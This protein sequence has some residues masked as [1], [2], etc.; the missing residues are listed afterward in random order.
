[1]TN[2]TNE[3][4]SL[5]SENIVDPLI[6]PDLEKPVSES[7]KH[8]SSIPIGK[9]NQFAKYRR[10]LL[11]APPPRLMQNGADDLSDAPMD[12]L[13]A[14]TVITRD[15]LDFFSKLFTRIYH[16]RFFK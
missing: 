12:I 7:H 9:Y 10:F 3:L 2:F 1:M 5:Q 13:A 8:P 14:S 11:K 16:S 4:T 15:V 6:Q